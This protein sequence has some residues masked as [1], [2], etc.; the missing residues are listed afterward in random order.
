MLSPS[1]DA[2][3]VGPYRIDPVS[4]VTVVR[5]I[6]NDVSR[7]SVKRTST[8]VSARASLL[9]KVSGSTRPTQIQAKHTART[10]PALGARRFT[11]SRPVVERLADNSMHGATQKV[12]Q[13]PHPL[14]RE[15]L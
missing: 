2:L 14:S 4:R 12:E 15:P 5:E 7:M 8:G 11:S 3:A 6:T 9:P 1:H 10:V 13:N